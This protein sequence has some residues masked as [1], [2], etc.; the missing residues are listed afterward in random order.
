[1]TR[2]PSDRAV[3]AFVARRGRRRPVPGAIGAGAWHLACCPVAVCHGPQLLIEADVVRGRTMTSWPSVRKDLENDGARWV[4]REVGGGRQHDHVAE[5]GGSDH[6]LRGDS[7]P[8]RG[9]GGGNRE[10]LT[11]SAD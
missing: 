11:R 4:D 5:A 10:P 1:P 8:A 7:P 2:V 9:A 6:V 3:P